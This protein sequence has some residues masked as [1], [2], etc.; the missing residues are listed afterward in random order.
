VSEPVSQITVY[1][2]DGGKR[3][4]FVKAPSGRWIMPPVPG[5]RHRPDTRVAFDRTTGRRL[6]RREAEYA[7][8]G[9]LT[10]SQSDDFAAANTFRY[11]LRCDKCPTT[12]PA[13]G[14][15]LKPI[16]DTQ[17][18]SLM[19]LSELSARLTGSATP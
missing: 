17:T 1:C 2:C 18:E 11:N 13:L 14:E 19:S 16:F 10:S 12:V 15:N 4:D 6:A 5:R 7:A 9:E 3:W 8:V